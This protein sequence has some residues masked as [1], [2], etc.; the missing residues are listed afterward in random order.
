[1]LRVKSPQDFGAGIIFIV[2]GAAGLIFGRE[3]AVGTASRMG[4]GYF[5]IL[6]SYLIIAIGLVVSARGLTLEG[7][8]VE[9]IH[10]RPIFFVLAAIL[11]AGFLLNMVGLALTSV[12]V[13]IIAAYARSQVNLLETILLGI[14]MGIFSVVV[15]VYG[16]GQPLPAWWGN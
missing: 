10:L 2:V 13:A 6:L 7:P 11:A 8:P 3:L 12:L 9:R 15:F 14:G 4:P 5:P 16:L 1:M